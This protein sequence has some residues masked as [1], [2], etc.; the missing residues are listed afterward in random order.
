MFKIA[1]ENIKNWIFVTGVIRSGSTFV[2]TVLSLPKE[3][4][5]IHE[6]FNPQCGLPCIDSWYPY[7]RNEPDTEDMKRYHLAISSIFSYDF[8]LRNKIPKED[9]SWKRNLKKVIGSRGPFNLRIAKLNPFHQ[10][11]IIKDPIGNLLSEYLHTNFNVKPVIII[12]HPLSFIAS[13]K[14]VNWYPNPHEIGDK[15]ELIAD[16]FQD[17]PDFFNKPRSERLLAAAAHW[18]VAYKVMLAQA[19]KYPDWQV[20]THEEL[21]QNPVAIFRN[22]YD[23]L[24]LPWSDKIETK[25]I[26]LTQNNS[27]TQ[28]RKGRVQ[29]FYRNSADIFKNRRDSLTKEER[30]AIFDIVE[31]IALKIYP[32]ESFALE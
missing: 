18:R 4:D 20:I 23:K 2:G 16:Y 11:A 25:I 12:K 17:E 13:V 6:P 3:V 26:E 30:R 32:K 8:T 9:A 1:V 14:K 24:E 21:S 5:Y 31:D 27:S 28:A 10:A 7:L 15:P 29:D 22:L 19:S